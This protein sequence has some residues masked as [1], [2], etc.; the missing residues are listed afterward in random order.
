[1][2]AK[3]FGRPGVHTL[4]RQVSQNGF[5][6]EIKTPTFALVAK[7]DPVTLF[8][9]VPVDDMARNPNI[10]TAVSE[11]GGHCDYLMNT[12]DK[13]TNR[14]SYSFFV[15]EVCLEYFDKV[16]EFNQMQ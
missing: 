5:I 14:R 3:I 2:R 1:M 6:P 11:L 4:Y 12:I 16:S 15:P 13:D 10:I 7:D 8:K 9:F